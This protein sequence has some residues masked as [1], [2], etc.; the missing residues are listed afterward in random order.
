MIR[1]RVTSRV[2]RL[3]VEKL[4]DARDSGDSLIFLHK[5][6]AGEEKVSGGCTGDLVMLGQAAEPWVI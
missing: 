4:K 1:Q 5:R 6:C 2:T 3:S